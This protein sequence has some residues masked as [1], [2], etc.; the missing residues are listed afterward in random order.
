MPGSRLLSP[1]RWL[2]QPGRASTPA[3]PL[4]HGPRGG[5]PGGSPSPLPPRPHSSFPHAHARPPLAPPARLSLAL[6][7]VR[8]RP[9]SHTRSHTHSHS[10]SARRRQGRP[11]SLR[12]RRRAPPA[13][14]E[15][16]RGHAPRRRGRRGRG[17]AGGGAASAPADLTPARGPPRGRTRATGHAGALARGDRHAGAPKDARLA[18]RPQ[19]VLSEPGKRVGGEVCSARHR[20]SRPCRCAPSR[21][22]AQPPLWAAAVRSLMPA[23]PAEAPARGLAWGLGRPAVAPT[24]LPH[25]EA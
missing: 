12:P 24:V 1:R 4:S 13:R 23:D 22:P 6:P 20:E 25:Q 17:A 9:R 18:T 14:A 3:R 19:T 15:D 2:P 7:P 5:R 8:A 10:H 16:P 21:S 11:A